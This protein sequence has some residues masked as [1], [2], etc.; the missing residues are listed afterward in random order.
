MTRQAGGNVPVFQGYPIQR[1]RGFGNVLGGLLK[2]A[3]PIA[4]SAIIPAAKTV[5]KGLVRHGAR[6]AAKALKS[7][8]RRESIKSAVSKQVASAIA[9][10][11][12]KGIA[13]VQRMTNENPANR[14]PKRKQ[15][16]RVNAKVKRRKLI[17]NAFSG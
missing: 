6:H 11:T 14:Q 4:K 17:G 8:S 3:I 15:S 7:V 2:A 5:G 12:Q 10:A 9:D 1:G 16:S 13:Q